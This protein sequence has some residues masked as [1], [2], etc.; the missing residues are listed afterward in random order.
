MSLAVLQL[1]GTALYQLKN[2]SEKNKKT[3]EKI[4]KI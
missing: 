3:I 4:Y 2:I 1:P